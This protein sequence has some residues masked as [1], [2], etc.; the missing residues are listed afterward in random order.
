VQPAT[1][2]ASTA[3]DNYADLLSSM[4]LSEDETLARVRLAIEGEP[5]ARWAQAGSTTP[6][7]LPT[8]AGHN[9]SGLLS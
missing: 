3:I 4:G 9:R 8:P 6:D 7:R 5:L 1:F 2:Y